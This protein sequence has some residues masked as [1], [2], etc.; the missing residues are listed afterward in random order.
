MPGNR[1]WNSCWM[2]MDFCWRGPVSCCRICT[3]CWLPPSPDCRTP[4]PHAYD[5]AC[6]YKVSQGS[7]SDDAVLFFFCVGKCLARI[8]RPVYLKVSLCGNAVIEGGLWCVWCCCLIN[9]SDSQGRH[10]KYLRIKFWAGWYIIDMGE[11][12]EEVFY[13]LFNT[14]V[15]M[16]TT[17]YRSSH[18]KGR[19][20]TLAIGAVF[21][22]HLALS[23]KA[24]CI[25]AVRV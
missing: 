16:K 9:C 10:M 2:C 23:S 24:V 18:C 15:V 6:N 11:K 4:L 14:K 17:I 21:A 7:A 20:R 19:L 25:K 1:T 8:D 5:I 12:L 13:Y 22:R 3:S